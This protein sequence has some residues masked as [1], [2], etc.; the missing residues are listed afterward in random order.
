MRYD[1][2][3]FKV[4]FTSKAMTCEGC[5]HHSFYW[6][7]RDVNVVLSTLLTL[8]ILT[9]RWCFYKLPKFNQHR[10]S[11]DSIPVYAYGNGLLVG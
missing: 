8:F 4:G 7:C 9:S 1:L 6:Q 2:H 3:G 11:F 10:K 5:G